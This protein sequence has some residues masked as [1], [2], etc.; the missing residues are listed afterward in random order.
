MR[1]PVNN[2]SYKCRST[3]N[4][5]NYTA[6]R[7]SKHG[8][9]RL[10]LGTDVLEALVTQDFAV[11]KDDFEQVA[12]HLAVTGAVYGVES[13]R[14]AD[15]RELA[16]FRLFVRIGDGVF[17][18]VAQF[19]VDGRRRALEGELLRVAVDLLQQ[20]AAHAEDEI[21]SGPPIGE[22]VVKDAFDGFEADAV[23][24]QEPNLGM[25]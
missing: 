17:E 21:G 18:D 24:P 9:V 22:Y 2:R 6:Y 12:G 1:R 8:S 16:A 3:H 4:K 23:A 10:S 13:A 20:C 11:A 15:E 19:A 14:R 25:Q 5:S 7:G